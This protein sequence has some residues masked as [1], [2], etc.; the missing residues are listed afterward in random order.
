MSKTRIGMFMVLLV[1]LVLGVLAGLVF[2]N[3]FKSQVP[4]AVLSEFTKTFSPFAFVGTGVGFGIVIAIW[5][6]LVAWLSPRFR[7]KGTSRQ[8]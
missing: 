1:S 6:M 3:L 2:Q 5:S 7:G 4:P 8:V